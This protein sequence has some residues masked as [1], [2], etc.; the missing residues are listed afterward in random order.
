[1]V[2]VNSCYLPA[3]TNES[4]KGNKKNRKKRADREIG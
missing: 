2:T 1:V 3:E 4:N